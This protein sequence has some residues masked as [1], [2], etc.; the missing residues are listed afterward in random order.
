MASK[1]EPAH[2]SVVEQA[3]ASVGG[4]PG[5]LAKR[6]SQEMGEEVSR[7]RVNGWR[8]RGVFPREV[9]V[10]VQQVCRIPLATLITAKPVD[11]EVGNIVLRGI[12]SLG[13]DASATTLAAAMT[14]AMGKKITRQMVNGWMVRKQFPLDYCLHA[15]LVTKIPVR[16]LLKRTES[17][18]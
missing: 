2:E 16:L 14:K 12:R 4:S 1:R 11:R 5:E 7:Q 6:L 15:H 9:I 17:E 3:I 13:P 8:G 18:D 10:A